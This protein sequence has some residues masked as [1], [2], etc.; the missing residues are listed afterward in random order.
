MS[1][2]ATALPPAAKSPKKR[3]KS[4]RKQ[5]GPTVSDLIL[6]AAAASKERGGVS[7]AALKKALK[8]GG[9]DVVKNKA[10][11]VSA[12]KRLVANKSLVQT[13]GTGAS[14]SFKLNK[15]PPTPRKKKV[16]RKKKPKAKKVKKVRA[17]KAAGGATPAAKKSP[18]KKATKSPKKAKRP[19]AAKK[20][21][22][23][24][25]PKKAKRVARSPRTRAA[26]KK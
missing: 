10:R 5:T 21:K 4:Q 22:K 7:L 17:K 24:K 25:S 6:K 20:P 9:Y 11:I 1:S 14:G 13:K 26:A 16:V 12:I 18:K 15:K 23:P 3:A 8:A 19:A 2:A